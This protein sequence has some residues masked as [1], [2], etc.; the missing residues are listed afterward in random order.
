MHATANHNLVRLSPVTNCYVDQR[1][2]LAKATSRRDWID[3][4]SRFLASLQ[5]GRF[6]RGA[7][8]K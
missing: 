1:Q 2:A 8:E 5:L 7:G 6:P 4:I 3:W